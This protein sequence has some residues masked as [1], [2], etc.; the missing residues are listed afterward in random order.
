MKREEIIWRNS[1][2]RVR[3]N[4]FDVNITLA[5]KKVNGRHRN[6]CVRFGLLNRARSAFSTTGYL[7]TSSV[8]HVPDRIYFMNVDERT[9][10]ARKISG[11]TSGSCQVLFTINDEEYE[12]YKKKW[13]G[14]HRLRFDM[15]SQLHYIECGVKY[16]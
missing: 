2:Y 3:S 12:I 13:V 15:E 6:P 7:V 4:D 14:S 8:K 1:P 9:E 5:K 10:G 16:E 11:Q